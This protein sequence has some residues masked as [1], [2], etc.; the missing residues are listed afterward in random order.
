MSGEARHADSSVASRYVRLFL[1]LVLTSV[2]V[3]ISLIW[4]QEPILQRALIVAAVCLT[5]WLTEVVPPYVPTFLQ[6][7]ITFSD[8]AI[9]G[10]I[11]MIMGCI[12]VSIT[13]PLV[14]NLAGIQ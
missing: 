1:A 4:I 11:L 7:G 5:L 14:L 12:L 13:G 10:L 2:C 9:P 8:L 6:G 3:S